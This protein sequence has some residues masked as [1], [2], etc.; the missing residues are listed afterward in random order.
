MWKSHT[1]VIKQEAVNFM[2]CI[3]SALEMLT[4]FKHQGH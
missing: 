3:L 2:G 1:I 4:E